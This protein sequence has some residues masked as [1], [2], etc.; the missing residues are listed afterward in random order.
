ML[1]AK[2]LSLEDVHFDV[3]CGSQE[4][5]GLMFH[6]SHSLIASSN[7]LSILKKYERQT[8]RTVIWPI[9]IKMLPNY[10]SKNMPDPSRTQEHSVLFIAS[11]LPG[12]YA[13][14]EIQHLRLV[15]DKSLKKANK[16]LK[17]TP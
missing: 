2:K 5:Y 9:L 10:L 16:S 15:S 7:F 4:A 14:P 8:G 1:P 17:P 3:Q 11:R 12:G 6:Y 13:H